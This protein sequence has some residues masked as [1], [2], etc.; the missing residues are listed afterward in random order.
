[1]AFTINQT[2]LE[3]G[4]TQVVTD[5]PFI[6]LDRHAEEAQ[7]AAHAVSLSGEPITTQFTRAQAKSFLRLRIRLIKGTDVDDLVTL[8]EGAGPVTVKLTPGSA[9][10]IECMFGAR[11]DQKLVPYNQDYATGKSDGSAVDSIFTQY[12]AELFLLRL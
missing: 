6:L 4:A 11:K 2:G 3:R 8:M 7:D 10:T 1:M 5:D 12:H 9:T